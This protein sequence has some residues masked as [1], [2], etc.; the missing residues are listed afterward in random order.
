MVIAQLEE[1]EKREKRLLCDGAKLPPMIL[2]PLRSL[3]PRWNPSNGYI[4]DPQAEEKERKRRT[5]WGDREKAIFFERFLQHPKNFKKISNYLDYKT[6]GDCV[7]Y[8]YTNKH[9]L[10]LKRRLRV[11]LSKRGRGIMTQVKG[12]A[13]PKSTSAP[14]KP[15]DPNAFV[16]NEHRP[17]MRARARNFSYK[18]S[19][20]SGSA[21]EAAKEEAYGDAPATERPEPPPRAA[22]ATLH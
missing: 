20:L 3:T 1:Q 7:S 4:A 11:H 2:E 16:V 5:N 10:D 12:G 15:V 21:M 14:P 22:A 18:E 9:T 6:E 13:P 17:G 8:Y 19:D